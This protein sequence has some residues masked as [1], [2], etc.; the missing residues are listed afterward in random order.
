M[1]SNSSK[2][3]AKDIARSASDLKALDIK[4]LDISNLCSFADY[5]IICS[6]TSDRHVK[7]VADRIVQDQKKLGNAA[8]GIEGY[9]DGD[10]VLVDFGGVIAHIFHPETR[11]FYNLER[12]WGDARKV[13]FTEFRKTK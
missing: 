2:D 11:T 8:L 9:E 5:F 4:V 10:W 6:G 13:R 1:K 7:S 3:L 12:L